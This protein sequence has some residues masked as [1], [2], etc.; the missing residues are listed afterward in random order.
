MRLSRGIVLRSSRLYSSSVRFPEPIQAFLKKFDCFEVVDV[1]F[2]GDESEFV[3]SVGGDV[4]SE[5]LNIGV[6]K[7]IR[8]L[9]SLCSAGPAAGGTSSGAG[10]V[11]PEDD[12]PLPDGVPEAIQSAWINMGSTPLEPS[13]GRW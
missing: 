12:A 2:L 11:G 5:V 13:S 1:K 6:V 9:Y 4:P 7:N 3:Q 8:K 10:S